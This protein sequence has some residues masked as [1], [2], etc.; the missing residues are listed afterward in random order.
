MNITVNTEKPESGQ[1][2]A[3]L[4]IAKK[5]VD[6]AI[7]KTYREIARKYAFQGF[8]RG[9][10]PRPVIDGIVGRE[11]VLADATN[12]LLVEAEPLMLEQ[13]DIVP[14]GQIDY[15]ENPD[16][17]QEKSDYTIEAHIAVRP[18][19]ALDS[20]DAPTINMPHTSARLHVAN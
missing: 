9:R 18:D 5:D 14:L 13:L 4:T 2:I 11:A 7:K 1:L 6:A 20:Y 10:A 12:S 16:L 8:R 3:T 17:A 15:G 19:V